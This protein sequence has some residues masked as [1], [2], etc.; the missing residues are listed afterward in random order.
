M[1]GISK[2]KYLCGEKENW[3]D[4]W[5]HFE[6]QV[7]HNLQPMF[8]LI[9]MEPQQKLYVKLN[10]IFNL[11]ETCLQEIWAVLWIYLFTA[12]FLFPL[13]AGPYLLPT[14]SASYFFQFQCTKNSFNPIT[15]VLIELGLIF[16]AC[17]QGPNFTSSSPLISNAFPVQEGNEH[18]S[19]LS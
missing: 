1:S 16:Q 13:S 14:I 10:F 8:Y 12:P 3:H 7:G 11:S 9:M 2:E 19:P 18:L 5:K 17:I 4:G 15:F 6:M